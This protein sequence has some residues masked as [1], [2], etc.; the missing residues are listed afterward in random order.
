MARL[1]MWLAAAVAVSCVAARAEEIKHRF[2]MMDESRHAVHCVDESN[3]DGNWDLP[4]GGGIHDF[5]LIGRGQL[6]VSQGSGYA[7]YDMA[8]RKTVKELKRGDLNGTMSVRARA[9]GTKVVGANQ[10]GIVVFELDAADKVVRKMAFPELKALRMMRL[11]AEGNVVLAEEAGVTEAA[12]DASSPAGG[13]IVRRVKLPR[14]RNAFMALKAA[15][16]NY[17]VGA[18]FAQAFLELTPEGKIVR[19]LTAAA[20]PAPL[21]NKFYAGF[22][23]L[24]NGH[25]VVCN[26]TGHA[27]PDSKLGW[28][29][30]QFDKEGKVV[31]KWHDPQR[32][33]TAIGVIVLDDLDAGAFNHDIDGVLGPAK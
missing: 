6:L 1:G 5:Q 19:D 3:P 8:T 10:K 24:K 18:G 27:A 22:Q 17:L 7:V 16:G 33:G 4:V 14:S 28:Q 25:V 20:M 11:T 21:V 26:W 12:F 13:R 2:L 32:A 23:V 29:L 30:V 9:D 15:S 31:W